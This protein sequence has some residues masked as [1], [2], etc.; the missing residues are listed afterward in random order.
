MKVLNLTKKQ[1]EQKLAKAK[2]K[3][4]KYKREQ[5]IRAIENKYKPKKLETNKALAIYLFIMLNVI[6][7]YSMVTMFILQDL[8]CL[9]VLI[10]D[11]G[12]QILLYGIYCLKAYHGKKQEENMKY[13][14]ERLRGVGEILQA[15]EECTEEIPNVELNASED[16]DCNS[17]EAM[18]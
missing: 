18:G 4:I 12:A 15:G 17:E 13:K 9:S 6:V 11:I 2:K 16:E 8:S 14:R 7:I 1:Y 10:T 3:S 5:Q